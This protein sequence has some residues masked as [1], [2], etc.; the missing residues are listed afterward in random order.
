M[1][2]G[3]VE[4]FIFIWLNIELSL[5]NRIEIVLKI[6]CIVLV[7]TNMSG[8]QIIHFNFPPSRSSYCFVLLKDASVSGLNITRIS[9]FLFLRTVGELDIGFLD[10]LS[11][12]VILVIEM[13]M[14]LVFWGI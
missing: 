14:N 12:K 13:M 4:C 10:V 11:E 9:N 5:G 1:C 2:V 6:A 8:W 3:V 7:V